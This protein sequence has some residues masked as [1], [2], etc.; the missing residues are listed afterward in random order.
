MQPHAYMA[1]SE[2]IR[3]LMN[4]RRARVANNYNMKIHD[5]IAGP[6][7]AVTDR[8]VDEIL[9]E[10]RSR[11][12]AEI[13]S[14]VTVELSKLLEQP[15]VQMTPLYDDNRE[16][17]RMSDTMLPD[18]WSQRLTKET[19]NDVNN[20]NDG[21]LKP[22]ESNDVITFTRSQNR[23]AKSEVTETTPLMYSSADLLN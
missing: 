2:D 11:L 9:Y 7:K 17:N 10:F 16:D 19:Q 3:R 1:D 5:T 20:V 18:W 14:I 4:Q 12:S 15:D 6:V 21:T 22:A 23:V 8:I 13:T